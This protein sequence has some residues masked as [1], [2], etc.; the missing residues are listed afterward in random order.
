MDRNSDDSGIS[1][2]EPSS[3]VSEENGP[4]TYPGGEGTPNP[5]REREGEPSVPSQSASGQASGSGQSA[6]NPNVPSNLSN[7]EQVAATYFQGRS[8]PFSPTRQSMQEAISYYLGSSQYKAIKERNAEYLANRE[9]RNNS[10]S[11]AVESTGGSSSTLNPASSTNVPSG[12]SVASSSTLNPASSTNVP[13]GSSVA[14]SSDLNPA[15]STNVPSGSSVASSSTLNQGAATSNDSNY[16]GSSTVTS[17]NPSGVT[18]SALMNQSSLGVKEESS[19]LKRK[20][21]N[22]DLGPNKRQDISDSEDDDNNNGKGG[23]GGFSAG[24]GPSGNGGGPGPS[25]SSS[26]SSAAKTMVV[27]GEIQSTLA[28]G[29]PIDFVIELETTTCIYDEFNF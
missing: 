3:P 16:L 22:N 27:E 28:K 6:Q 29:S 25:S 23:P 12:S 9:A 17:Q 4:V 11:L 18:D 10:S 14:S 19:P 8:W 2:V 1:D 21:S 20:H 26:G 24:G 5:I 13:S 15:S 7:A